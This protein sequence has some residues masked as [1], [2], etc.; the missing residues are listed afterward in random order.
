MLFLFDVVGFMLSNLTCQQAFAQQLG[1]N[2][3]I[4]HHNLL[5]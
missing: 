3:L 1:Q 4:S 2:N 5:A